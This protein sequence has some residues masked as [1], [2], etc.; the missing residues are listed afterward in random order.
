MELLAYTFHIG[1]GLLGLVVLVLDIVAIIGLLGGNAST[2][3]KILWIVLI[4]LFPLG[5]VILYYLVGR[6]PRDA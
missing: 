5:G 1:R 6:S 4:L 3:H 2:I